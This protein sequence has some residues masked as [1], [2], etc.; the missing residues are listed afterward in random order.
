QAREQKRHAGKV[1]VVL[2]GLVGAAEKD[3]VDLLGNAGMTAHELADRPSREIVRA[4]GRQRAAVAADRGANV[5]ADEG[6][7]AHGSMPRRFER[8][9]LGREAPAAIDRPTVKS[10][11]PIVA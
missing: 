9:G 11:G 3:V 8:A 5:V 4:H 10:L 6:F 1:A 7:G 2:A